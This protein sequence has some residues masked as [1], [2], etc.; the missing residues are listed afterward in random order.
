MSTSLKFHD[1]FLLTLMWLQYIANKNLH[2]FLQLGKD[3]W[4]SYQKKLVDW[5]QWER[6][7]DKLPE[8]FIK[9]RNNVKFFYIVCKF[10]L[11]DQNHCIVKVQPSLITNTKKLYKYCTDYNTIKFLVGILFIRF[12]T[13]LCLKM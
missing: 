6:K 9:T 12:M 10:L 1:E 7:R 8:A 2:L 13:F 5:L 11:K 3:Y 4:V